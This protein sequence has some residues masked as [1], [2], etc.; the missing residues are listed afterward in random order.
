MRLLLD[1]HVALWALVDDQRLPARGRGL[2][3]DPANRIAVSAAS[4]WE[5]AIKHGLGRGDMPISGVEALRWV[6]EAGFD[7]LAMTPEHAV[8]VERLPD[9]HRDP[10]DRMLV[11][12]AMT[13]PMHLVT[14]DAQVARY[15]AA[16]I[17]V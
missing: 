1:T 16:V 9:H 13:E 17:L 7:L 3:L 4:L 11:A 2:I 6:N 8:A 12:Q 5:I 15:A 10:F 14:H